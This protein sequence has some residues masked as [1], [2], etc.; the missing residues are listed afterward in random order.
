MLL[1][2]YKCNNNFITIRIHVRVLSKRERDETSY[3]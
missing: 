2:N 3:M 1:Y